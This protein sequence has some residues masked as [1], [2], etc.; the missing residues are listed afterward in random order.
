MAL[1]KEKS[2][3]YHLEVKVLTSLINLL[4][5]LCSS[6]CASF[7]LIVRGRLRFDS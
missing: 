6:D 2:I 7:T 1:T 3:D 4:E 5:D